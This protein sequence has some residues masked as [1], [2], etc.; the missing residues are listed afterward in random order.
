[1]LAHH[2]T[3]R[4]TGQK[5]VSEMRNY[6]QYTRNNGNS[7][8]FAVIAV[9]IMLAMVALIVLQLC[10]MFEEPLWKPDISYPLVNSQVSWEQTFH[11]GAF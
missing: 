4:P 5:G 8:G 6:K 3:G 1:M 9:I 7:K 11:G 10:G 2:P